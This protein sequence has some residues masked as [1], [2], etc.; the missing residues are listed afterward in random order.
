MLS[1]LVGEKEV[2]ENKGNIFESSNNE[3]PSLSTG[4]SEPAG[5]FSMFDSPSNGIKEVS[6]DQENK[7]EEEKEEIPEIIEYD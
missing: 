4:S 3:T 5:L 1:S 7:Q 6:D 2:F